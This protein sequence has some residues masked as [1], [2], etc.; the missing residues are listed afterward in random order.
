[1]TNYKSHNHTHPQGPTTGLIV[2]YTGANQADAEQISKS[3]YELT[4]ILKIKYE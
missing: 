3:N 4:K 1:L 2:P